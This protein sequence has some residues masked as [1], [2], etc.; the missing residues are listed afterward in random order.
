VSKLIAYRYDN[1]KYAPGSEISS[2][3]DHLNTTLTADRKPAELALRSGNEERAT[4][5][6]NCLYTWRDKSVGERMWKL[7]RAKFFYELE[8]DPIDLKHSGD[9]QWYTDIQDAFT[10]GRNPSDMEVVEAIEHYWS[11][12]EKE[13]PRIEFLVTRATVRTVHAR[14]SQIEAMRERSEAMRERFTKESDG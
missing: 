7:S 9:V 1:E 6:K 12:A 8:I 5:R 14:L 4:L 10:A 2:R 11:S 13:R 3:G